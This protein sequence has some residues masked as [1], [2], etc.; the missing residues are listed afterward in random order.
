[1]QDID[2]ELNGPR[3]N[4]DMSIE[5]WYATLNLLAIAMFALSVI[6][7]KE[8]HNRNCMTYVNVKY[9][10]DNK[11]FLCNFL[12]VSNSNVCRICNHLREI[13]N[14]NVHDLDL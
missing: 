13:H 11:K 7:F 4:V 2:L 6:I 14:Q 8:I 9:K 5:R 3:S 10:Y 1:M 12:F